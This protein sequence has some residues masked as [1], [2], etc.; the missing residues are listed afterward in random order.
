MLDDLLEVQGLGNVDVD[1]FF[2]SDNND[3]EKLL[4]EHYV[5][6][7]DLIPRYQFEDSTLF[8][9][10]KEGN[11]RA[12]VNY[13]SEINLTEEL[14]HV[15]DYNQN[16]TIEETEM[17]AVLARVWYLRQKGVSDVKLALGGEVNNFTG[18]YFGR[19]FM[20]NYVSYLFSLNDKEFSREY[21]K[22]V[23]MSFPEKIIYSLTKPLLMNIYSNST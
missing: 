4:S 10:S 3:L 5:N 6:Y 1:L 19:L 12:Y 15:I 16:R 11:K 7:T 23:N 21:K 13:T 8:I 20:K 18:N 9:E 22:F 2:V 17:N 14:Q